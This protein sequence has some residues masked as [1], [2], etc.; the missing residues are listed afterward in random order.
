MFF[1]RHSNTPSV[2]GRPIW[3]WKSKSL[4]FIVKGYICLGKYS[5]FEDFKK[6][7]LESSHWSWS[8]SEIP[9]LVQRKL[10]LSNLLHL[11]EN[12]INLIE[13]KTYINSWIEYI[14]NRIN[15]VSKNEFIEKL[16]N[17]E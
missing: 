5:Y 7:P 13:H 1:F 17:P 10:Y 2:P 9:V 15:E 4:Q 6:L 16:I 11:V 3:I 8:G 14:D 12:D